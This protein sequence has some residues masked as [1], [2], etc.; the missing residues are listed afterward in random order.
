M[1]IPLMCRFIAL[2]ENEINF[3]ASSD[4]KRSHKNALL[5]VSAMNDRANVK[6]QKS[7]ASH[8]NR[9]EESLSFLLYSSAAVGS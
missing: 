3:V 5:M 6:R 4:R 7:Y 8:Q 2:S 1:P 9:Q